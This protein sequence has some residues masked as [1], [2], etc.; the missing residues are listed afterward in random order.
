MVGPRP[1]G[2]LNNGDDQ[3][4]EGEY[5]GVQQFRKHPVDREVKRLP[6]G[7][8]IDEHPDS[9][10]DESYDHNEEEPVSAGHASRRRQDHTHQSQ[11]QL[12]QLDDSWYGFEVLH[13]DLNPGEQCVSIVRWLPVMGV[14]RIGNCD[15]RLN[16]HDLGKQE[17]WRREKVLE[18]NMN[19]LYV[20][21]KKWEV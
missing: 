10:G 7:Q 17:N 11:E 18:E 9:R 3:V 1:W 16:R 15:G 14:G 5:Y 21:S 13:I 19:F 6:H 12:K 8:E 2:K 20:F 4:E